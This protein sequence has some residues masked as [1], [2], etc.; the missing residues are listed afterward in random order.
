M[1]V[2]PLADM[3]ST[4]CPPTISITTS[5]PLALVVSLSPDRLT[6][7]LYVVPS[8]PVNSDSAPMLMVLLF[9]RVSLKMFEFG[10]REKSYLPD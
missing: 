6:T 9:V 2:C 4:N 1:K 8:G 3:V 10:S 7:A 5:A